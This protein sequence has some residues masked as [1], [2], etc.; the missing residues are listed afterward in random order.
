MPS[1]ITSLDIGS[2]QVKGVVAQQKKDGTLSLITA[3][4]HPSSGVRK[5][6]I[7]DVEEAG[8]MFKDIAVDLNKISKRA[9]ENVFVNVN[10]EHSKAR[11]SR[12]IVAVARADQEI[13]QDDIDRVVQ[14]SRAVKL[15]PNYLI[16]HNI[17]REY[18]VDDVGDIADPLGMT[19]SRLETSTLIVETFAPQVNMLV[20]YLE[21][22]GMKVGGLIFNPWAASRSVLS[23][24]Q[25]DLGVLIID[26]GFGSTTVAVYEESKVLHVKSIPV[27]AGYITNDIAIGLKTSIDVAEKLKVSYGFA[28]AKDISRRDVVHLSEID[29]SVTTEISRRFLA[30]IIEVRLA[31]IL[32]L[33]NNELKVLG[34]TLQLPAGVVVT[35][36][37]VKLAGITELVREELKLPVQIG[38]PNLQGIEIT[39]PAHQELLDDP[40]FATAVGLLLWGSTEESRAIHGAGFIKSF[41]K[42]LMP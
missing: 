31:E 25:K 16:L 21:R 42:N 8:A 38:F 2:T 13:H 30:E 24:K 35:G 20:K 10:S 28:L 4:K 3:F 22:V 19:G 18:F 6:V 14:A 17:I 26:F 12:G 1:I 39:N 33:I 34:R 40:E 9:L 15:L 7:V 37:G 5:G 11:S 41:L 27:G 29:P 32:D 23:K 36:G